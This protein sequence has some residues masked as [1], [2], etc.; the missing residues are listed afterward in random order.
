MKVELWG[1]G[2]S[3]GPAG[4]GGGGGYVCA[5]IKTTPGDQYTIEVGDASTANKDTKFFLTNNPSNQT[6]ARGGADALSFAPGLGGTYFILNST[7]G[8]GIRGESGTATTISYSQKSAT[9]FRESIQYG[10]GGSTFK[11]YGAK[12]SFILKNAN[13]NTIFTNYLGRV[14]SSGSGGPGDDGTNR[15]A[16]GYIVIRW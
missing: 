6:F 15:G 3:G 9:E 8:F 7:S 5:L 13:S 14:G 11:G 16:D 1:A 2:G 10:N 12:G 4:G